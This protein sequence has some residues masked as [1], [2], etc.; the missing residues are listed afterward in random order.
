MT[1]FVNKAQSPLS[2]IWTNNVAPA[3]SSH[4]QPNK[5]KQTS[6]GVL[7]PRPTFL[8]CLMSFRFMP[9]L[10]LRNTVAC[11]W[12]AFSV[13]GKQK[14]K[15]TLLVSTPCVTSRGVLKPRPTSL[16]YLRGFRLRFT[17]MPF[18]RFKKTVGC[19]WNERS[20]CN[21]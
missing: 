1:T 5:I 3:T 21:Y 14:K 2:H 4:H 16:W 19:F 15:K 20:V 17:P 7:K 9:P 11:F 12:N 6:R 10:R 18:L 13:Y 8:E